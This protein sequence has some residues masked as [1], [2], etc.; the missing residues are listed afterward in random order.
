MWRAP[1]Q[2]SMTSTESE[3][4][5]FSS[6]TEEVSP[7]L[8]PFENSQPEN[9]PPRAE[10]VPA[11]EFARGADEKDKF[12]ANL[13]E[14][15]EMDSPPAQIISNEDDNDIGET[16]E[17]TEIGVN[18][19]E[20]E[21]K[22]KRKKS[23]K[24]KNPV[25]ET[26]SARS[27]KSKKKKKKKDDGDSKSKKKKKSK[28]KKDSKVAHDKLNKEKEHNGN[29]DLSVVNEDSQSIFSRDDEFESAWREAD[30]QTSRRTL[31]SVSEDMSTADTIL[32]ST[33]SDN[34]YPPQYTTDVRRSVVCL[35]AEE[36]RRRAQEGQ[37][38]SDSTVQPYSRARP[39]AHPSSVRRLQ[40]EDD[41]ADQ[42]AAISP[43]RTPCSGKVA[44]IEGV[45]AQSILDHKDRIGAFHIPGAGPTGQEEDDVLITAKVSHDDESLIEER[46]MQ[47]LLQETAKASV[48]MVEHGGNNKRYED[49]I[50]EAERRAALE[51]YRP[52]GLK[53]KMFGDGKMTSLDI[54]ASPDDYIRRRD[55]LPW[56]V[57][58]NGTTN[59]WVAN[60][61]TNQKAWE[62]AQYMYDK[63]SLELKRSIQTFIGSTEQEAYEIGLALAPPLMQDIEESPIC[64]LCKTKFALLKRPCNCRNCGVVVCFSC[65]CTWSSKQLPSTYNSDKRSSLPVCLACDWLANSFQEALLNGDWDRAQSLY[66][67]GNVN[68]RS[69]YA[70]RKKSLVGDEAMYPIHMA[71][72]G[73]NLYLVR[74]LL[75][76]H[77]CPLYLAG[78]NRQR[79]LLLTSKGRSPIDMAMDQPRLDVLKFLVCNQGLN[80]LEGVKKDNRG[81]LSH[82]MCL[83]QL[84]PESLLIDISNDTNLPLKEMSFSIQSSERSQ[85]SLSIVANREHLGSF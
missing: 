82:L 16:E 21:N 28:S 19:N 14:C 79:S 61:Q 56:T 80:L 47:R 1:R 42:P 37:S 35:A 40:D 59:L 60:V 29:V 57:K 12:Y 25:D 83:I 39:T 32:N 53:E 78:K 33:A 65:V 27:K 8:I 22:E 74:W 69:L 30:K 75:L 11:E 49:P 34:Y 72:R 23:K 46:V 17:G 36:T 84:I 38:L 15:E 68:L 54:G 70:S 26:S 5:F 2:G 44:Y 24:K 51:N 71:I 43:A 73:G 62:S 4:T 66:A 50:A 67:T 7:L 48:I 20:K 77:Y 13:N 3:T 64:F 81:C 58:L 18:K 63:T 55:Y 41:G 9:L 85:R 31:T 76:D 10:S 6:S 45:K 52:Q